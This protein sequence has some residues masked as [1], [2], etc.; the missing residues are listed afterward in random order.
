MRSWKSRE[1]EA[2]RSFCQRQVQ[3]ELKPK[4]KEKNTDDNDKNKI[5]S[6][7]QWE[8]NPSIKLNNTSPIEIRI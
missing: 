3:D 8:K 5:E 7:L 2:Q 1:T 4:V 6:D